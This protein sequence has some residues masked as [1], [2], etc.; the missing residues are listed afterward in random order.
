M[1]WLDD[2]LKHP[3]STELRAGVLQEAGAT[4]PDFRDGITV[5]VGRLHYRL[6]TYELLLRYEATVRA[7]ERETARLSAACVRL[8]RERDAARIEVDAVLADFSR[9]VAGGRG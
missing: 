8:E 1:G 5:A 2:A 7:L 4:W 6:G 3:F 9:R